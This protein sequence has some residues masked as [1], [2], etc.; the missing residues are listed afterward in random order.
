MR[1]VVIINVRSISCWRKHHLRYVPSR[2][3]QVFMV[4]I[5]SIHVIM[6]L[7]VWWLQNCWDFIGVLRYEVESVGSKQYMLCLACGICPGWP[8]LTR[9]SILH[10]SKIIITWCLHV[11]VSRRLRLRVVALNDS[12]SPHS[13]FRFSPQV[14]HAQEHISE[15]STNL[16]AENHLSGIRT[17]RFCSGQA[18][19]NDSTAEGLVSLR[20]QTEVFPQSLPLFYY[21]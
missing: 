15:T 1:D 3:S 20:S 13:N 4:N 6:R 17:P 14:S 10:P 8:S 18:S 12:Y 5:R 2:F 11:I 9:T 19:S 16:R 7:Y 21:L